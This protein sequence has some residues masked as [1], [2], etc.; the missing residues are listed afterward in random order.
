MPRLR[1]QFF[2]ETNVQE[3]THWYALCVSGCFYPNWE[4]REYLPFRKQ[5]ALA[6]KA[7]AVVKYDR[8]INGEHVVNAAPGK[9]ADHVE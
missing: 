3:T 1:M 5:F 8:V 7:H 2:K 6:S 4:L 9:V